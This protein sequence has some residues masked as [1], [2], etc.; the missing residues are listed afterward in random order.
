MCN[1]EFV[2]VPGSSGKVV[3]YLSSFVLK[4]LT[5]FAPGFGLSFSC[6]CSAGR[7]LYRR[8]PVTKKEDC[9]FFL[10]VLG[11]NW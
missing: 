8:G 10:P 2:W 7:E 5:S 4:S 3:R 11:L 1:R 9:P 6:L